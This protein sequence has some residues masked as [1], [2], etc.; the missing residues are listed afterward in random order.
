MVLE[1]FGKV[2][3][4]GGSGVVISSQSG[5]RMP[6]LTAAQDAQL[7]T[8]SP[9]ALLALDFVQNVESTLHAYRGI[10]IGF[11]VLMEQR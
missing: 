2:I 4:E 3:A 8:A 11:R 6:A 1:E 9:E 5:C 7:A 10:S